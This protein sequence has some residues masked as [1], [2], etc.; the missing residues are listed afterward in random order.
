MNTNHYDMWIKSHQLEKTDFDI[1]D[2]V[3]EQIAKETNKPNLL[4]RAW[5]I[6]LFDLLQT[7]ALLR[8]FVLISG[9]I[10]GLLR[11]IFVVYY[12]LF[13]Y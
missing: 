12:A 1:T 3:M 2:S 8:A 6:F 11:M 13:T 9:A 7:K 5:Q 10:A 4:Q